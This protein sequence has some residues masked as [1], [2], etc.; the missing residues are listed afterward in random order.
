VSELPRIGRRK[1][2]VVLVS[3]TVKVYQD[4]Q[5]REREVVRYVDIT[6]RCCVVRVHGFDDRDPNDAWRWVNVDLLSTHEPWRVS[7]RRRLAFA[8]Q[9]LRYGTSYHPFIEIVREDEM[10]Q[11]IEAMKTAREAAFGYQNTQV[12]APPT[13]RASK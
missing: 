9:T 2:R 13:D 7:W 1:G 10:D 11:V 6:S 3:E 8:W 12:S 5:T 4:G